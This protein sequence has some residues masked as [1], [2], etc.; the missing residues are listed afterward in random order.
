MGVAPGRL[1]AGMALGGLAWSVGILTAVLLGLG[2]V[3]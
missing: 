3:R 2:V 1:A